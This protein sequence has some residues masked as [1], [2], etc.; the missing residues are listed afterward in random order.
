M[1]WLTASIAPE[2]LSPTTVSAWAGGRQDH[3]S[4]VLGNGELEVPS[5]FFW[6]L[7]R[8]AEEHR[9]TRLVRTIFDAPDHVG[10][11]RPGPDIR[12][13]ERQDT[14]VPEAQA[15]GHTV[16][17]VVQLAGRHHHFGSELRVNLL[18]PV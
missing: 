16:G 10:E 7:V 11:E 15:A 17:T 6:V 9:V 18:V 2:R 13:N 4:H 1:R 12:D 8:V 5:F 3:P 14:V